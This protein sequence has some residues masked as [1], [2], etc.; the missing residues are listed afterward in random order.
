MSEG[1]QTA[2]RRELFG[3]HVPCAGPSGALD[4]DVR[5]KAVA[6]WL[7]QLP[8]ADPNQSAGRI[9]A[10]LGRANT[11]ALSPGQR[12]R[13][14]ES[15]RQPTLPLVDALI[16]EATRRGLPVA[17]RTL[18]LADLA[19]T[20]L[21]TLADAYKLVVVDSLPPRGR[22]DQDRLAHA[23][24]RA[25]GALQRL[26]LLD[27]HLYAPATP[28][29]WRELHRL[30]ALA[31]TYGFEPY[32][33]VDPLQPGGR[34]SVGL[35]YR[36]ALLL[37]LANPYRLRPAELRAL[38]PLVQR[39]AAG[40]K[41]QPPGEVAAFCMARDSDSPPGSAPA[42]AAAVG[43]SLDGVIAAAQGDLRQQNDDL[44]ARLL[45]GWSRPAR[46]QYSRAPHHVQVRVVFGLG[47][48]NWILDR[49]S[50]DTERPS[51]RPP[52]APK[53]AALELLA[54]PP[55]DF[56]AQQSWD[57]DNSRHFAA[58]L[59]TSTVAR[60]SERTVALPEPVYREHN[61]ATVDTSAQG[62]CLLWEDSGPA[63]AK[64][65]ELLGL[66]NM[67]TGQW[68]V[69]VVRWLQYLR[70]RGIKM[71][72][73]MIAPRAEPACI[74]R[75]D[76]DD[77]VL[78]LPAMTALGKPATVLTASGEYRIGNSVRMSA[79]GHT[80]R[81]RLTEALEVNRSFMRFGYTVI[82]EAPAEQRDAGDEPS[83]VPL[84]PR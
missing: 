43:I 9:A 27:Y 48:L 76:R 15:L 21:N 24:Q 40:V 7:S 69:G 47:A 20:V 10:L 64:V 74:R 31:Q 59:R 45:Q 1:Q 42:S 44:L 33:V 71:G 5:P 2:E 46:R 54:A 12:F 51:R 8:L 58:T 36:S 3:L 80:L 84:A 77:A 68:T 57:C 18:P 28:G 17:E 56:S 73:E 62:Y 32:S 66:W 25:L 78:H 65:G 35:A 83:L 16:R 29:C 4:P 52:E 30:S 70:R 6:Q 50:A 37:A 14:A 81:V 79:G 38:R 75:S 61:L 39:Y 41:L 13:M 60:R 26:L 63:P 53:A 72:V 49:D 82:G 55:G 11:I 23:S 19:R 34:D 22:T 67:P